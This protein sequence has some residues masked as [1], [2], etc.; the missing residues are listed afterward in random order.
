MDGERMVGLDAV[1]VGRAV[2][3]RA[4][5]GTH[6]QRGHPLASCST[7]GYASGLQLHAG[8]DGHVVDVGDAVVV[9]VVVVG[10]V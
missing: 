6:W 9:V 5:Y 10:R 2:V 7:R 1:V 3:D 8:Y 4:E